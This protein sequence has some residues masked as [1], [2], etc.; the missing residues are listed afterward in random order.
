MKYL[1]ALVML[2]AVSCA[3]VK[4]G[5][6]RFQ[7]TDPYP[8]VGTLHR[9]GWPMCTVTL[10]DE[11]VVMTAAHC[12]SPGWA[13]SV[14]L[15]EEMYLASNMVVHPTY[16]RKWLGDI[17]LITLDRSPPITPI[18]INRVPM[19][20]AQFNDDLQVV[21]CARGV[22]HWSD[23]WFLGKLKETDLLL[24]ADSTLWIQNGDSG[25]PMIWEDCVAGVNVMGIIE[26]SDEGW[27]INLSTDVESFTEW[28]DEYT[29]AD[30]S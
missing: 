21:G 30:P 10:I 28:I 1:A 16:N 7:D 23:K 2:L 9:G 13:Y 4:V 25:G 24:W 27:Q 26:S 5:P 12:V 29:G 11:C 14:K 20:M 17:A 3:A 8:A 15:G 22:K 18:P 6:T 19:G